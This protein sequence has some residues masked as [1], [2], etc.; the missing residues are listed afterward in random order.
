[1]DITKIGARLYKTALKKLNEPWRSEVKRTR[2][3]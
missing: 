1:M 2:H 3:R